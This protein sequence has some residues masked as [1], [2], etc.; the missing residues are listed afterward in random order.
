MSRRYRTALAGLQARDGV[1]KLHADHG[2]FNVLHHVQLRGRF[3]SR[4]WLTLAHI[5]ISNKYKRPEI[6]SLSYFQILDCFTR[7]IGHNQSGVYTF[8]VVEYFFAQSDFHSHSALRKSEAL[9][10]QRAG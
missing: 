5:S 7:I 8:P 6:T 3:Y 9:R 2:E 4:I 10:S 1:H